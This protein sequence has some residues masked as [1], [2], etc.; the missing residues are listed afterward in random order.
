MFITCNPSV[1]ISFDRHDSNG[2]VTR[3]RNMTICPYNSSNMDKRR[4]KDLIDKRPK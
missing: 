2:Q 1:G 4:E 3:E